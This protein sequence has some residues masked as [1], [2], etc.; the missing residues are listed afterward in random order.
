MANPVFNHSKAFN[1]SA[2]VVAQPYEAQYGQ[3]GGYAGVSATELGAM[4]NARSAGPVDTG[5]MTYDDVLV[6]SVGMLAI[7]LVGATVGWLFAPAFPGMIW[8]S[9][10]GGVV[11]GLVNQFK[12]EPS[13]GLIVAYAAVEGVFLG[14]ISMV[15]NSLWDGVVLQAVLATFAVFGTTLALFASGKIRASAKATKVV[16][17]IMVGY[18]AFSLINIFL[19]LTGLVDDPWGLRGSITIM[20]IP[21]GVLLGVLAVVLAAYSFVIDFDAIQRG[22]RGGAPAKYAWTAAFALLFTLVWL[23]V[24]ILRLLAILQR[25]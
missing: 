22:V 17:L 4:Y 12:R 6:K 19:V 2:P 8:I 3:P 9:A 15:F 21:L 5:R 23:Y 25:H 14:S 16:L 13:P 18:A 11:L 20:G 7:L 24:E 1:G 10:I